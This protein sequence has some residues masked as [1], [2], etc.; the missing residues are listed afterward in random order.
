MSVSAA[1]PPVISR[2]PLSSGDM[3]TLLLSA[4]G[5]ALEFY[6]FVIFVY[7][8]TVL[9]RIFFPPGIPE[10]LVQLQA[11]AIF[12][13]GYLARPLGGLVMAHFGD[14][15]GRKR[16]FT[17]SIFLMALSTLGIAVLPSYASVG[18]AAPLLLLLMRVLQGAAI[19]GEVPGAWVFVAE[20]VPQRNIGLACGI[21]T[22]GL[23]S[24]ILLGSLVATGVNAVFS[25][26]DIAAYAWRLPFLLGG[27]F[28]FISVYLR[29]FL[30]ETPVFQEMKARKELAAEMPL[31]T[32]V[33]KHIAAFIASMLLTWVLTGAIV[34]VILMTP[35]LLQTRYG[36]APALA[37]Q[38]NSFAVFFLMVG[39]VLTGA[40]CDRFGGG[41]VLVVGSI[42]LGIATYALYSV[43]HTRPDL[44]LPLYGLAGLTV[45]TV[46]AVPYLLVRAYP[47]AV[48]F[49]GVSSSYNIAYAL[50]GGLTP[51]FVQLALQA[52]SQ[53]P[54]HYM[55]FMAALGVVLGL[56]MGVFG[57]KAAASAPARS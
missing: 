49:T 8:I 17:F 20:H 40:L 37:L 54:T 56:A 34:V 7:F 11:F 23:S 6:D 51:L 44:L 18:I 1:T 43:T 42:L 29:Q 47:P 48:A 27:L 24:G 22:C 5:G 28:G 41:R 32:V 3:R 16:M 36:I 13:A 15:F 38:A 10:W 31:K 25:A 57:L 30:Q 12:A 50:F 21:V 19:G 33:R 39:C 9:G 52:D 4:L 46:A 2:R 55:L 45:G 14:L 53:A 26:A 35:A